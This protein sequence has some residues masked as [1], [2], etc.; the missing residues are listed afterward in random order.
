M[1]HKQRLLAAL[2]REPV[3]RPPVICPGG[4]MSA[5]VVEAMERR[6]YSWPKAHVEVEAMAGL[7]LAMYDLG[8]LENLAVPFCMTVEAEALGAQV[9]FGDQTTQ[10][11][12]ERE[13]Y[14]DAQGLL[15]QAHPP[16]SASQRAQTM[17]TALEK[18]LRERPEAPVIGN[19]VGPVSLATSLV[20]PDIFL[21]QMF[22]QPQAT[23]EVLERLT[24]LLLDF[25]AD[26]IARGVEIIAIAD[27]T[28]TGEILGPRLF[29]TQAVPA[30]ARL[31]QGLQ[32]LGARVIV[33]I[34]GNV[35]TIASLLAEIGADAVSVD[36]MVSLRKLRE[37]VPNAA[38]MGN[39]S[40]LRL[41]QN[42][43]ERIARW[44]RRIGLQHADIIAPACAV[45][46]TTPLVNL[47]ALV[48]S[49]AVVSDPRGGAE[50]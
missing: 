10:P 9:N 41:E 14:P 3:D 46:P 39:F 49:A 36:G 17:L 30:L 2:R 34:C 21:K 32:A 40:T 16:I 15:E 24:D 43:P 11:R 1:T 6:G 38:V 26:Q 22:R 42:P 35:H 28:A 5:A 33:H 29:R 37:Q 20:Q 13:P 44:V 19:L 8:T 31:T 18:V 48:R 50:L 12:V 47:Q 27:P 7:A 23:Q 45:V 25:G 4:M